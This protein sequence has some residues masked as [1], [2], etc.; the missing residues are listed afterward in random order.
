[1]EVIHVELADEGAKIIVFE[2]FG[3]NVLRKG[4]RVL[5]DEAITFLVPKYGFF[6]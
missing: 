1:M 4:I 3:Q 5:Y 6:I 2:V